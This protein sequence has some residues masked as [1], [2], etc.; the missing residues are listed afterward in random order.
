MAG[1]R[2]SLADLTKH[3]VGEVERSIVLRQITTTNFKLKTHM[4]NMV[5]NRPCH[6]SPKDCPNA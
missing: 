4:I 1:A 3:V 2:I 5:S 6:R